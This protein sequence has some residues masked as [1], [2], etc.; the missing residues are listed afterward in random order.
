MFI[1]Y[2]VAASVTTTVITS[3]C[4]GTALAAA[5]EVFGLLKQLSEFYCYGYGG[6]RNEYGC[7]EAGKD[8]R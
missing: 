1:F 2:F 8:R 6:N 4:S 7:G 3:F 5:N